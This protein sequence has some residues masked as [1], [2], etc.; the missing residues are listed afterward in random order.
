MTNRTS[1]VRRYS[2]FPVSW[3][4]LYGTDEFLAEGTVLDLTSRG[5][6]LAGSMPVVPG[7][8]VALQV[9]IPGKAEPLRIHRA[10]VLWVKDLEFAIDA[11]EM[12]ANDREWVTEFLH[13]KLGLAWMSPIG[14]QGRSGKPKNKASHREPTA[15]SP[16]SA[17]AVEETLRR[18]LTTR[19]SVNG[20]LDDASR[21]SDWDQQA[22][23]PHTACNDAPDTLAYMA[24]FILR[25][26]ATIKAE[27]ERTGRDSITDN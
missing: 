17:S 20:S 2:R 6:R 14:E 24:R 22:D 25:R 5:W 19:P 10:T 4:M 16:I 1:P 7:L 11:H 27:R 12:S 8:C 9:W 26:M 13:Q 21:S 23:E 15:L 18:L 3:R